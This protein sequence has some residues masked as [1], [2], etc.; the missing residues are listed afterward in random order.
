MSQLLKN[1]SWTPTVP[2]LSC[3]SFVSSRIYIRSS[4]Q[5]R[6]FSDSSD[7]FVQKENWL[8]LRCGH[9]VPESTLSYRSFLPVTSVFFSTGGATARNDEVFRRSMW[10]G[11]RHSFFLYTRQ[12]CLLG[13]DSQSQSVPLSGINDFYD[14][15]VSLVKAWCFTCILFSNGRHSIGLLWHA[16]WTLYSPGYMIYWQDLSLYACL[17]LCKSLHIFDDLHVQFLEQ[18]R[19][20]RF[21]TFWLW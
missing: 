19:F 12:L 9:L 8:S 6:I 10:T 2:V 16:L 15:L 14:F 13:I 4:L 11:C 21:W 7:S 1:K 5:I 17:Y 20:R 18:T 3:V